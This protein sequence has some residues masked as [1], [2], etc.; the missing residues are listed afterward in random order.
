MNTRMTHFF[1]TFFKKHSTPSNDF[2]KIG[3][4]ILI[5]KSGQAKYKEEQLQKIVRKYN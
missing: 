5:D 4:Y 3:V 2:K 1:L